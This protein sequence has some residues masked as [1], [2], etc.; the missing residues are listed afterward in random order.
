MAIKA[1]AQDLPTSHPRP[2][3][4]CGCGFV[5]QTHGRGFR[6]KDRETKLIAEG[7]TVPLAIGELRDMLSAHRDK[8]LEYLK[9]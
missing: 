6:V 8:Q 1:L 7:P 3:K 5:Y 4:K 9:R 2:W